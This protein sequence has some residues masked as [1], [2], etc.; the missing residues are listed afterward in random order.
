MLTI[1]TSVYIPPS[2]NNELTEREIVILNIAFDVAQVTA[3]HSCSPCKIAENLPGAE[4]ICEVCNNLIT[5]G[6]FKKGIYG[7]HMGV[8]RIYSFGLTEKAIDFVTKS[9]R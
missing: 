5:K 2:E 8:E 6:Y 7:P 3:D 1:P 4:D 9:R